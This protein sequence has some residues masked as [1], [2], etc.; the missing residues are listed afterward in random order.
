MNIT[1]LKNVIKTLARLNAMQD[2]S[3]AL[4]K[5]KSLKDIL[6][7]ILILVKGI[8]E[9]EAAAIRLIA[10][11]DYPYYVYEGFDKKFILKENSLLTKDTDG[12]DTLECMCGQV[13][14]GVTNT[15]LSFFTKGGSFWTNCTSEIIKNLQNELSCIDCTIR[16]TCNYSGYESVALIPLKSRDK[17]IG[18]IQLNDSRLDKFDLDLI[19]FLE[20]LGQ[21]LGLNI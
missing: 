13:I 15:E 21:Q 9:C 14:M 7:Q 18:L 5:T 3:L 2:I 8:A 19:L 16:N 6:R 1:P 11:N 17:N 20:L 4:N 12:K 10:N